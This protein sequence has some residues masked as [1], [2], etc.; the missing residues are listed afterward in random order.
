MKKLLSILL[1]TSMVLSLSPV[2]SMNV[3]AED[4]YEPITVRAGESETIDGNLIIN[5]TEEDDIIHAVIV[6]NYLGDYVGEI[7]EDKEVSLRIN[8]GLSF[9]NVGETLPA[10][11]LAYDANANLYISD[12]IVSK[13]NLDAEGMFLAGNDFNKDIYAYAK[14]GGDISAEGAREAHGIYTFHGVTN[15]DVGG[16]I[17]AKA[18]EARGILIYSSGKTKID[19]NVTADNTASEGGK[20]EG[21][22]NE[23]VTGADI[24]TL[25]NTDVDIKGK[26]TAVG[27]N[28]KG[29][30]LYNGV[31]VHYHLVKGAIGE[32]DN[33]HES[34]L[35]FKVGDGILAESVSE[36]TSNGVIGIVYSGVFGDID[37]DITGDIVVKS[38][39]GNA[40]GIASLAPLY[41]TD[42][43]KLVGSS[44]SDGTEPDAPVTE[45]PQ[46]TYDNVDDIDFKVHGSI[47][48]DGYGIIVSN[49]NKYA[50]NVFLVEDTID[51][52]Q[53]GLLVMEMYDDYPEVEL[54]AWKIKPNKAGNVAEYAQAVLQ[55]DERPDNSGISQDRIAATEVE[56]SINYI[57]RAE[58][59]EVGGTFAVVKED[60]TAL[61]K[62]FDFEVANEGD[63]LYVVPEIDDGYE[64]KA[65]YNDGEELEK[66]DKG[67]YIVVPKGGGIN[68]SIELSEPVKPTP[69]GEPTPTPE[70]TA[71]SE[72]TA[73]PEVTAS[74]EISTEAAPEVSPSAQPT[75]APEKI[76]EVEK[77]I[78]K[79]KSEE[80]LK[81]S[82]FSPLRLRVKK[83]YK[84]KITY[85]WDPVDGATKYYVYGN[86]CWSKLKMKKLG[87]VTGN[88]FTLKKLKNGKK[89]EPGK[90]Y[91]LMVV[92]IDD[93]NNVIASSKALHAATKGGKLT[94]YKT[95]KI[96][97]VT[98]KKG[99]KLKLKKGS[100]L[101][102]TKGAVAKVKT[103]TTKEKKKLDLH[104]HRRICYESSDTTV[105]TVSKSGKIKAVGKG[106]CQIYAYTQNGKY[107][108]IN[109]TVK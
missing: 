85:T 42:Q 92:A 95:I 54:T 41:Q 16:N 37:A 70:A 38:P 104:V 80:D 66:D 3:Y 64:L 11:V 103:K 9:T 89:V 39:V 62:S 10:E 84:N 4:R 20:N 35:K 58:Q 75:A 29:A 52:K 78:D 40:A 96:K 15:V 7:P 88:S 81:G 109:L 43:P 72:A 102:L 101:T 26:V 60:G 47:I 93:N 53:I 74:P 56:K 108:T 13:S 18:P 2:G 1:T 94:N 6:S 82:Q 55:E 107:T 71:S 21:P 17:T 36:D 87:K 44:D 63:K 24:L 91:K 5:A 45:E 97:K 34:N 86:K 14:V 25:Y 27:T 22:Y 98:D 31:A 61:D 79:L 49:E 77:N 90:Y 19:G 30:S 73:T 50:E 28:V 100:K 76:D 69:T 106:T 33:T 46:A 32:G 23:E 51:A 59:P 8:G 67:Y 57:V 68:L 83:L 105:A 12:G 99:K 65:V 48:S